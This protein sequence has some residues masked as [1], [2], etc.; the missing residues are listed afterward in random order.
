LAIEQSQKR[1]PHALGG[2]RDRRGKGPAFREGRK[3]VEKKRREN[4]VRGKGKVFCKKMGKTGGWNVKPHL[5]Q[6]EVV[7]KGGKEKMGAAA[8]VKG[9]GEKKRRGTGGPKIWKRI[10]F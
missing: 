9:W 8:P 10:F 1:G 4:G 7:F 5:P 6:P 3:N 2:E